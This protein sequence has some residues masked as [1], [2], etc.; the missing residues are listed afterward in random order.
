[1]AVVQISKIQIRRGKANSGTG[2]PQLASGELAWA[3]DTQE[4][5]IGNGSVA[6]GAPAVGNTKVITELDLNVNGNILNLLQYIY[7][8]ADLGM[9]TGPSPN[10]PVT[11]TI[12]AR[13]DDQITTADFGAIGDGVVDDTAALQRA[14]DQLFLNTTRSKASADTADGIRNRVVLE[15][16]AGKYLTTAPLYVPSYATLI[17]AGDG[18]TIIYYN[19]VLSKT[20]STTASQTTLTMVDAS[21]LMIGATITGNGVQNNTTITAVNPGVSVTL[22][23]ASN[24]TYTNAT[25]TITLAV[26][27]IRFVND[28]STS[29]SPSTLATTTYNNQPRNITL[30]GVTIQTTSSHQSLLQLDAVRDSVFENLTL[31][32]NWGGVVDTNSKAI[33]MNAVSSIVTCERNSFRDV[34]ISDFT[35]GVYSKCDIR[36]NVFR[37]V[38]IA[39][40]YQGFVLGVGASTNTIGQQFGP[41]DT[42]ISSCSFFNIKR[43]GVIT[44]YGSGNTVEKSKF[45][46]VGNDGGG[47]VQALYPQIYFKYTGNLTDKIQSDRADDL[48]NPT[49]T[50]TAVPYVPE[51]AGHGNFELYGR[52]E[53]QLGQIT[54]S[55][56]MAFRLPLSTDEF[57]DPWRGISYEINYTYRSLVHNFTRTGQMRIVVDVDS[58]TSTLAPVLQLSDD[59]EF[60]GADPDGTL[61][62]YLEFSATLLQADGNTYTG[63]LGT[64]PTSINVRYKNPYSND[65]GTF[66][67]SYKSTF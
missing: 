9:Q 23:L 18:K 47:N 20:G 46:N 3:L 64:Y 67:Y 49:S 33:Y 42:L 43:H 28:T 32:G 62:L 34:T 37:E 2:I 6:E 25:Y 40:G 63:T 36:D 22:S 38:Y 39:N 5:Y 26:P 57:G 59:Y 4:L 65:T 10:T 1:M 50:Y 48:A 53:I 55:A 44:E 35:F 16:P 52:R 8:V 21:E 45:V 15:I 41:R 51:V 61:A 31:Q 14:I 11:R 13:L 60:S 30:K 66:I 19:P 56:V 54:S 58:S 24:A 17:G 7:K 12:Q 29:G 27:A